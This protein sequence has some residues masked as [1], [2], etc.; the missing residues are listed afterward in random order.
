MR[1]HWFIIAFEREG[2]FNRSILHKLNAWRDFNERK[3]LILR[4][5]RQVGKTTAIEIFSKSYDQFISLNL[6]KP[7]EAK[8]F[9]LELPVRDLFQSILLYKNLP[10]VDGRVLLFLDEIQNSSEAVRFLRYFYEELPKIHVVAAGSLL[11]IALTQKQIGVPVGRVQYLFMYPMSFKEFLEAIQ[12]QQALD[13]MNTIPIPP[14]AVSRLLELFHRYALIGGMPEVIS[15]YAEEG[16]IVALASYY[17]S[18]FTSFLDDIP[19]YAR[20]ETMKRIIRHC[21]EA[22]P[23]EAGE[24][25]K[26]T[27]FGK[28]NYRS[29]EVGDALRTLE[30]AML[31]HLLYPT[32]SVEIPLAP[33]HKKSPRLQFLDVG[34]INFSLGLQGHY[35]RHS[36][37]HSF[38]RGKIAEMIVGQE[39]IA[40]G[41]EEHLKPVFW[42]REKSQAP[43]EVDFVIQFEKYAVPIEVK[44]GAKGTLKSLHQF[45]NR[46][47]HPYAV[48]LYAGPLEVQD[49][50]TPEGK[51]FFL[52]NLPYFLAGSLRDYI[53]WFIE[54]R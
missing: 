8:L 12:E 45:I 1:Q 15:R 4:G 28:S 35:F 14:F 37:L 44:A 54:H 38:F 53:R 32:T 7:E 6:E 50:T 19:K 31:V 18:L 49:S 47:P 2:M 29:R 16:N 24:R 3:P 11:E 51:P 33:D 34:L 22:A 20:N 39:L 30:Q 48:R 36:D 52:L 10:S 40:A 46:S 13:S 43:A 23:M 41:S 25:I 17:Q 21:F 26:F 42:V 27:G 5:A 9:S